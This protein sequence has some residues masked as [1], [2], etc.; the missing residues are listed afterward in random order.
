MYSY[1]DTNIPTKQGKSK[2]KTVDPQVLN[3]NNCSSPHVSKL[4]IWSKYCRVYYYF[5]KI[6]SSDNFEPNKK[7]AHTSKPLNHAPGLSRCIQYQCQYQ[8]QFTTKN[9][10]QTYMDDGY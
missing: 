3:R 5:S 9:Q 10:T 1:T 4:R 8:Y 7:Y 6:L 2:G